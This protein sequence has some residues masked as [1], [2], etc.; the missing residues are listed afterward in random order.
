V[1]LEQEFFYER[2]P[3]ELLALAFGSR[4]EVIAVQFRA[5][6][7]AAGADRGLERGARPHRAGR[8]FPSPPARPT[9]GP[10]APPPG[11]WPLPAPV[12]DSRHAAIEQIGGT[13]L[14]LETAQSAAARHAEGR[15][16]RA[17]R[18]HLKT[19][20]PGAP[21]T[22]GGSH[23]RPLASR[24]ERRPAFAGSAPQAAGRNFARVASTKAAEASSIST[25]PSR[26]RLSSARPARWASRRLGPRGL[27]HPHGLDATRRPIAP[28][29][30]YPQPALRS[31]A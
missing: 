3:S 5:L 29:G 11:R 7:E 18:F 22:P 14:H 30:R 31:R 28:D 13:A 6:G 4:E 2:A 25:A 21:R 27:A 1:K 20:S 23:P 12:A 15:R 19:G 17:K 26:A 24:H 16:P 9:G 10:P 8:P